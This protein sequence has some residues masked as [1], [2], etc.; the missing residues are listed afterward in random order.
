M[1][2]AEVIAVTGKDWVRELGADYVVTAD[3]AV[4]EIGKLTGGRMADVVIDPPLDKARGP[5][6]LEPLVEGG[7]G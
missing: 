7:S 1:M 3:K 2:G 6:A 5:P 4:D